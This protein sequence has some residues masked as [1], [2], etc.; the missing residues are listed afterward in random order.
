MNVEIYPRCFTASRYVQHGAFL[1]FK[2]LTACW[3]AIPLHNV[4]FMHRYRPASCMAT[5]LQSLKPFC[6]EGTFETRL[7]INI[8]FFVTVKD[9]IFLLCR[10]RKGQ[11]GILRLNIIIWVAVRLLSR[12]VS[13]SSGEFGP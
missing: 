3:I 7:E 1:F 5:A 11:C 13:L 8:F 6:N 12:M 9:T 10:I 4:M 2:T